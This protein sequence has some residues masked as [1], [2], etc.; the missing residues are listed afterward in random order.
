[1]QANTTAQVIISLFYAKY[2]IFFIVFMRSCNSTLASFLL[3]F[4]IVC[5]SNYIEHI[6]NQIFMIKNGLARPTRLERITTPSEGV[7]LSIRL[8]AHFIYLIYCID[9]LISYVKKS[10]KITGIHTFSIFRNSFA[11]FIDIVL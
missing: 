5:Y 7:V 10:R 1:M 8:R 3:S 11:Y 4:C 9:Y 2:P 6:A